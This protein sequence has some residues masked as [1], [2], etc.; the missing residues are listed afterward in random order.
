MLHSLFGVELVFNLFIGFTLFS[1]C[2]PSFERTKTDYVARVASTDGVYVLPLA[3]SGCKARVASCLLVTGR[4]T[5][6]AFGWPQL[7]HPLRVAWCV[8]SKPWLGLTISLKRV[9]NLGHALQ[10][11][12]QAT[13]YFVL[14]TNDCVLVIVTLGYTTFGLGYTIVLLGYNVLRDSITCGTNSFATFKP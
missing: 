9:K 12:K 13:T 5:S 2:D 4:G 7:L 10:V 3:T 6:T 8:R 1:L 11:H 14:P